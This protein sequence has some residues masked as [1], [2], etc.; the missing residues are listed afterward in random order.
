MT[1]RQIPTETAKREWA[2]PEFVRLGTIRE[3]AG[4]KGGTL[5]NGINTNRIP[6]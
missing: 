4:P 2:A 5:V 6:T 3:I 1:D